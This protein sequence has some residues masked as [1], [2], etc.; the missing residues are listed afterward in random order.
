MQNRP[1]AVS[2]YEDVV[3]STEKEVD[4]IAQALE[5]EDEAHGAIVLDPATSARQYYRDP[6]TGLQREIWRPGSSLHYDAMI[7]AMI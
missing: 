5:E 7:R 3:E 6:V 1:D 2:L 4:S